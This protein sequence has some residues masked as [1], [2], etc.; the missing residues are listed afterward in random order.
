M[1][2]LPELSKEEK[3]RLRKERKQ[4]QKKKKNKEE[5]HGDTGDGNSGGGSEPAPAAPPIPA[6]ATVSGDGRDCGV[7]VTAPPTPSPPSTSTAALTNE[8]GAPGEASGPSKSKAELRAERRARQ[9]A[10]R[11][12]KTAKRG[13]DSGALAPCASAKSR[14]AGPTIDPK[15]KPP[16]L[17]GGPVVKR[18]S[19]HM[20]ADD[21]AAQKKLAKKLERQQVPQRTDSTRKVTL[22]S[23]LHQYS[24]QMSLTHS[25]SLSSCVIHPSVLRLG[26]QYSQ[27]VITGSNAR[28][29]ALLHA[30]KQ[31]IRD[32]STPLNE[33]LCRDLVNKLKPDI[34]FLNQC[35][36]LAVSMGNAIK[37][38]KSCISS[39][40]AGTPERQ[41]KELLCDWIDS[42]VQNKI[43]L[44]AKAIADFAI[45]KIKDGDTILVYGCSSLVNRVLVEARMRGRTFRVVLVDSRPRMEAREAMRR[46]VRHGVPCTY[47]L[48][49]AL[50]Y[51]MQ[52]VSKVFLGAHAL[53]ANGYVMSRLGSSQVTLVAKAYNVPV[54]IC[55]ETY[56]FCERVQTDSF[57]SNE[58]DDPDNL[59][60]SRGDET[61]LSGW[62]DVPSL[63]LLNLVYDV[64]PPDFVAMVITDVGM[65][66][67]TSVPVVLR[68]KSDD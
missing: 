54:L 14:G 40:P 4:Q 13:G 18:V 22:F 56:K 6:A 10:E 39:I 30:F 65:I 9:E 48:V 27:G 62:R 64:T 63:K 33:D 23:H 25:L 68:V 43:E 45:Q 32:Y 55:C 24:R 50:A 8:R 58:L 11:L 66:P 41:A 1:E 2:E 28:A 49:T 5:V 12:G 60:C 16:G 29:V 47:V 7:R 21:P 44:A 51:A 20:Q 52:E 46:L 42:F 19:E 61:P 38:L 53:L 67:C 3:Q 36:P 31:V 59:V 37:H 26:L 15:P 35:R 17:D 57:V 34:S